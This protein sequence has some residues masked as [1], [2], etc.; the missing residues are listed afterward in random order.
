MRPPSMLSGR[1]ELALNMTPMIDVVFLLLVFFVWTTG[2]Q[3]AEYLLPSKLSAA[4]GSAPPS[5][6]TPPPPEADFDPVVVRVSWN[7]S[8]PTWHVNETPQGSLPEL[9]G[10]L[11]A[12]AR[13]KRDAPIV[14]HPTSDVP[15]GDVIDVYDISRQAGFEKIQFA[16]SQGK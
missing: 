12:I 5:A 1:G 8:R 16:A 7:G 14:L 4:S 10:K 6:N 15:L 3:I 11:A 9:K 13:I 2:S